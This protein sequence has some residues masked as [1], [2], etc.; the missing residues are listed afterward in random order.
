MRIIDA[1]M[2]ISRGE[3]VKFKLLDGTDNIY[4]L[5]H[6]CYLYDETNEEDVEWY[7]DEDW[8]NREI[9]IIKEDKE[10]SKDIKWYL[11]DFQEEEKTKIAEINMNF[12]ILRE[13]MEEI[14]DKIN[15]KER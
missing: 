15:K 1:M 12:K 10:I 9:R 11:I 13:K 14:I 6:G 2:K 5:I 7:I 3:E 4:H 8:L